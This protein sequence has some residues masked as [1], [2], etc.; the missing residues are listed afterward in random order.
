MTA[1]RAA[2]RVLLAMAPPAAGGALLG[3]V[4]LAGQPLDG[5]WPWAVRSLLLAPV[6]LVHCHRRGDRLGLF[7]GAAVSAAAGLVAYAVGAVGL[8]VGA[9]AALALAI[10]VQTGALAATAQLAG[11]VSAF[12]A[13]RAARRPATPHP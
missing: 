1:R 8:A 3:A 7:E 5:P 10:A 2:R 13:V 4:V 11:L 9:A 12:L 6:V